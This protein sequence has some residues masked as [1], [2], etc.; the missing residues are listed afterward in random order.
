MALSLEKKIQS[1]RDKA[2]E[3]VREN[4]L[5]ESYKECGRD[6]TGLDFEAA[7]MCHAIQVFV[8]REVLEELGK[9]AQQVQENIETGRKKLKDVVWD[10]QQ[11]WLRGYI[12]AK[13]ED[14]DLLVERVKGAER[15][16]V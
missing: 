15:S 13:K 9:V 8:N 14:L 2:L 1:Q 12:Q 5:K 3:W 11:D 4:I 7:G 16:A 10:F 6:T